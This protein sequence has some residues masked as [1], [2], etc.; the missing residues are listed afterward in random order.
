M[1]INDCFAS[2][3]VGINKSMNVGNKFQ[4]DWHEH[5]PSEIHNNYICTDNIIE[6]NV[7]TLAMSNE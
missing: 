7:T 4:N 6:R 5:S 2:G 1:V 3:G